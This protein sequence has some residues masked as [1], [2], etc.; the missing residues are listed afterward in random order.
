MYSRELPGLASVRDV[1]NPQETLGP[2]EWGRG[3]TRGR[4][5]RQPL[6]DRGRMNEM[7]NCGRAD[8][9]EGNN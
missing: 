4:G 5:G 1:P 3:L 7:R 9:E 8:W 2:R 6:E